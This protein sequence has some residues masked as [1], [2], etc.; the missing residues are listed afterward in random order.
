[1]RFNCDKFL[2]F[3][4][5]LVFIISFHFWDFLF[6]S[7][8]KSHQRQKEPMTQ[9]QKE[10]VASKR[11]GNYRFRASSSRFWQAVRGIVDHLLKS[12]EATRVCVYQFSTRIWITRDSSSTCIVSSEVHLFNKSMDR[13]FSLKKNVMGYVL[14]SKLKYKLYHSTP[15]S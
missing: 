6:I 5:F 14:T 10:P 9:R 8:K 12:W 15:T 2:R 1:M 4:L 3:E 13:T 7:V 11:A